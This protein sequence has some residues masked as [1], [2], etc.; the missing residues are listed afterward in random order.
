VKLYHDVVWLQRKTPKRKE[1]EALVSDQ[2][3]PQ[4]SNF[5]PDNLPLAAW[6]TVLENVSLLLE[7]LAEVSMTKVPDE[8][9]VQRK[10]F[11]IIFSVELIKA[12][13]RLRLL[14][15]N[16]GN[17]LVHRNVPPRAVAAQSL[18]P[19]SAPLEISVEGEKEKKE[20]KRPNLLD[21]VNKSQNGDSG[22][23]TFPSLSTPI[24]E[25]LWILRPLIYLM[26]LSASA[27]KAWWPFVVGV[28]VDLLSWRLHSPSRQLSDPEK[29]ELTKRLRFTAFFY[30]FRPP[31]ADLLFGSLE[32]KPVESRFKD[33]P[34][35]KNVLPM[36]QEIL[37]L[38]RT[39]YFYTGAS[40]T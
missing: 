33:V 22:K 35:V 34:L 36:V 38:Y 32:K 1:G 14:I 13:L 8:K 29:E 23:L 37:R 40:T 25:I 30:L 31:L 17:I 9:T 24:A 2:S 20:K 28:C 15:V 21:L 12:A 4:I 5:P 18:Q 10:K 16:N 39:R 6:L 7:I 26:S 3:P 19:E 27:E 11:W